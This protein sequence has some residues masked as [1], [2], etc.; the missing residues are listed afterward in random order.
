MEDGNFQ[1]AVGVNIIPESHA[2]LLSGIQ[3]SDVVVSEGELSDLTPVMHLIVVLPSSSP[4]IDPSLL[5]LVWSSSAMIFN[6][7]DWKKWLWVLL[8]HEWPFPTG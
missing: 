5:H 1:V 7:Y 4:Q 3:V 6:T 2:L 8:S